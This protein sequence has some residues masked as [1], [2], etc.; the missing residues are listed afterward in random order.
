MHMHYKLVISY[1]QYATFRATYC[2]ST[3]S[4]QI[5]DPDPIQR[6]AINGKIFLLL[7]RAN[8][9]SSMDANLVRTKLIA[10]LQTIQATSGLE[11]PPIIGSTKPA[12][13]LA[14]FDSKIWPVAI[15]MLAA[16]LGVTIADDV[17]IFRREHGCIALT[18]D[19]SV[20]MVVKH[21]QGQPLAAVKLVSTQ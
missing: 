7:V 17:N 16:E 18:I 11:C 2:T 13:D 3:I 6:S 8:V 12:D 1:A 21:V 15:G 9:E 19:E 14:Q 10:V 5:P 4:T 20:A